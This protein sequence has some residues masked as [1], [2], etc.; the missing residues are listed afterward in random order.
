MKSTYYISPTSKLH[1]RN[2]RTRPSS[3]SW[4]LHWYPCKGSQNFRLPCTKDR[5]IGFVCRPFQQTGIVYGI[6]HTR[7]MPLGLYYLE[8]G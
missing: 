3:H 7:T 8:D 4:C 2:E 6:K 5:V 1:T